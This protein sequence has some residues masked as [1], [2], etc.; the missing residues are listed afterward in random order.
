MLRKAL[1]MK[2]E[3]TTNHTNITNKTGF[4]DK[5]FV[6]FVRLVITFFG[7]RNMS[8]FIALKQ[9]TR[10]AS[11]DRVY[12]LTTRRNRHHVTEKGSS[13]WLNGELLAPIRQ[14]LF[15]P[16]IGNSGLYY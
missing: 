12:P 6:F 11:K 14:R 10:T 8:Y 9:H 7:L 4:S 13:S 15:P 1:E 3:F 5:K 2:R 16:V